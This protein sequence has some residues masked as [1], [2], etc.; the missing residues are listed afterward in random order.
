MILFIRDQLQCDTLELCN[1]IRGYFVNQA[2]MTPKGLFICCDYWCLWR[3]SLGLRHNS[4]FSRLLLQALGGH[5]QTQQCCVSSSH[6]SKKDCHQ[7]AE[8]THVDDCFRGYYNL[9]HLRR[10]QSR[11]DPGTCMCNASQL[12][13]F[14]CQT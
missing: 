3:H 12:V 2:N 8:H 11:S 9:R 10:L 13:T 6:S 4:A 1:V 14:S 5:C 7:S